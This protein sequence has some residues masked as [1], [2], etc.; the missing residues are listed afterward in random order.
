MITDGKN[1]ILPGNVISI[2]GT[3][4]GELFSFYITNVVH[5]VN[6]SSKQVETT[7]NGRYLRNQS[8][9]ILG[10]DTNPDNPIYT[11]GVGGLSQPGDAYAALVANNANYWRARAEE[12]RN[13]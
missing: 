1:K 4:D 9:A 6:I 3:G 11:A 5:N 12:I 10:G 2:K 8:E 7:I 13:A